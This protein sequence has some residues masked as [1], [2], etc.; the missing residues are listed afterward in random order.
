MIERT[1]LEE[2]KYYDNGQLSSV[3]QY[4]RA[5]GRLVRHGMC[6]CCVKTGIL[7]SMAEFKNGVEDGF[8]IM[9]WPNG[10]LSCF[11]VFAKGKAVSLM[12]FD[13]D[14]SLRYA[15]YRDDAVWKGDEDWMRLSPPGQDDDKA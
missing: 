4:M 9:L 12:S 11:T 5:N 13:P 3:V 15:E 2:R 1:I 7:V 10:R 6:W 8:H 14:G